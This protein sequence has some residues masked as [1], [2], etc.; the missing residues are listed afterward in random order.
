MKTNVIL[1]LYVT[2]PENILF[3]RRVHAL[4]SPDILQDR[5]VNGLM[6]S[7]PSDIQ[8]FFVCCSVSLCSFFDV[9][10]PLLSGI[11]CR[12]VLV[13]VRQCCRLLMFICLPLFETLSLS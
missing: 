11:F 5:A 13:D 3:C 12:S 10:F 7:A 8:R 1:S 2:G 9:F 4:F 6:H